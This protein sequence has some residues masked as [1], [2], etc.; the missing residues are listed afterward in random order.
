MEGVLALGWTIYGKSHGNQEVH[1]IHRVVVN[2]IH[3]ATSVKESCE[4]VL[5]VLAQD[6]S[7]LHLP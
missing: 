7:D 5:N 1:D 4:E 3:E 6:F 2:F